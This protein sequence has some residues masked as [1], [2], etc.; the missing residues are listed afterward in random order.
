MPKIGNLASAA[1]VV[2]PL[3][4]V[5]QNILIEDVAQD[6]DP[7]FLQISVR[8]NNIISLTALTRIAVFQQL[9]KQLLGGSAAVANMLQIATGRIEQAINIII[10]NGQATTPNVYA[11][12]LKFSNPQNRSTGEVVTAGEQTINATDNRAFENFLYLAFVP[13]NVDY[14]TLN[15]ANGYSENLQTEEIDAL[16]AT[17]NPSDASGQL[18][19]HTVI[20]AAGL[21]VESANIQTTS[22]GSVVAARFG[23]ATV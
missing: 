21:G 5:P 17:L 13:T 16:F 7:T 3:S 22:G 2:I 10:T 1:Q 11:N 9:G 23:L 14:V 6:T 15:Y 4:F 8:G 19:G 18:E 20:D 12:S